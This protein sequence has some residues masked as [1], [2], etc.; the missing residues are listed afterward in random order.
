MLRWKQAL[1][2]LWDIPFGILNPRLSLLPLLGK[3]KQLYR[4]QE[5][6]NRKM[7][8][9]NQIWFVSNLETHRRNTKLVEVEK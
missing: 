8:T 5:R 6:E 1:T 9:K 3:V 7:E 4:K 2:K